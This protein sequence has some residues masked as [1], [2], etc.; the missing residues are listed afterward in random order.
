MDSEQNIKHQ[1][2]RLYHAEAHLHVLQDLKP[3]SKAYRLVLTHLLHQTISLL[4]LQESL[5]EKY[6]P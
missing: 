3:G 4:E 5:G 6:L 1:L 2:K